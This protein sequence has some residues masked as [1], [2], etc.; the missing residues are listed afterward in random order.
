MRY[1]TLLS[2][3][4]VIAGL[5]SPT[6]AQTA[7]Q[8]VSVECSESSTFEGFLNA[9]LTVLH[10]SGNTAFE[11]VVAEWS[12]TEAGYEVLQGVQSA[13]LGQEKWTMLVPT[14]SALTAAGLTSS[15]TNAADLYSVLTYHILPVSVPS[16][17]AFTSSHYIAESLA[18]VTASSEIGVDL[19]LAKG[20]TAGQISVVALNGESTITKEIAKGDQANALGGLTLM[21]VDAVLPAP[22][23]LPQVL[24]TL[25][26][27]TTDASASGLSLYTTAL[28]NTKALNTLA[29]LNVT[30]ARGL[31]IF[32]PIDAAFSGEQASTN[33]V[34]WQKVL[35]GHYTSS[36]T[37]YSTGFAPSAK[38][39]MSSGNAVTFV[40]NS[41]GTFVVSTD[42]SGSSAKIIRSDILLQG[43]GVVD[44][45]LAAT[46][47]EKANATSAGTANGGT[48]AS[49][50]IPSLQFGSTYAVGALVSL[51]TLAVTFGL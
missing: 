33:A 25:A 22:A 1:A 13:V 37:I 48:L 12:E 45:L 16:Y 5:V 9:L 44:R 23:T 42:A 21:S 36:Q 11:E 14:D 15:Y 41:S 28:N 7:Q 50:A 43:G 29:N 18:P 49:G 17:D 40:S 27:A 32:A 51:A 6:T 20:K 3:L 47:L 34:A 2:T 38:I 30:N 39:F 24:T 4:S 31:T 10:Y 19:V 46:N 35:A 8:P 26:K